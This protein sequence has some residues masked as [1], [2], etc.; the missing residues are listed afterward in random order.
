MIKLF[1]E[2]SPIQGVGLF[3]SKA[4]SSNTI[5]CEVA[6][7]TCNK[8]NQKDMEVTPVGSMINHQYKS[9]CVLRRI[10]KKFY[11]VALRDIRAKE[12]LTVNYTK[13]P[14]YF[15]REVKGYNELGEN[16]KLDLKT[17]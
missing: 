17:E 12:E 1:I 5:I 11:L 10:L 6:D 8:V 4:I 15:C 3:T 13:L 16:Y 9:N 7:I 14:E 2:S